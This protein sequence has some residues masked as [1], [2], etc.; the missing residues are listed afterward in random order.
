MGTTFSI[1]TAHPDARYA[2]QAFMAAFAELDALESH[3]SRLVEGS[4]VWRINRLRKGEAAVVAPDTFRCLAAA[5]RIQRRTGGAFDVT[6]ASAPGSNPTARLR[7]VPDGCRVVAEAGGVQVDLG[8]IGKG[9]ALDRMAAVLQDWDV[10][11]A[12]LAASTSTVL[13]M[14]APPGTPGW[15]VTFDPGDGRRRLALMR[16]AL[17][18]SGIGVK[19]RHVVDPRTGR[20]ARQRVRAWARAT[21][22]AHA[23]ALSTAFLVMT[24]EEAARC[25]RHWPDDGMVQGY[26]ALSAQP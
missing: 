12:C 25:C 14:D 24:P 22:A 8:G 11:G 18:A 2:R 20:P 9:Y 1:E 10:T 19:G 16:A 7:L 4:D 17:S 21:T 23:D 15:S 5:L 3:L 26:P 6:Y 13:A